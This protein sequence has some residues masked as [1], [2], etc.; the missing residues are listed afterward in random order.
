MAYRISKD[1]ERDLDEIF[2]YWAKRVSLQVADRII[3]SITSRFW[4]LGEHPAAGRSA[5]DIASG[6][7]CFPA[8][9]YLIYYRKTRRGTDI[10]HIFHGA[11]D[12]KRAFRKGRK[13]KVLKEGLLGS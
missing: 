7:R 13:R 8:G 6:V 10:L 2:A 4:I 3:D 11:Q 9:K 12:Q 1:A 5:E